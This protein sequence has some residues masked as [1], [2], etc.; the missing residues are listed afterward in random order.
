MAGWAAAIGP[1][2]QMVTGAIKSAKTQSALRELPDPQEFTVSPEMRRGLRMAESR[3]TRGL[4]PEEE[5]A[6]E[7]QQAVQTASAERN[8]RNLG[9]GAF[10]PSTSA[11]YGVDAASRAAQ[12]RAS[13]MRRGEQM[14]IGQAA[15]LQAQENMEISAANE[16]LRQA[17]VALGQAGAAAGQDMSG[18]AMGIASAASGMLGGGDALGGMAAGF[19]RMGIN[20]QVAP[21]ASQEPIGSLKTLPDTALPQIDPFQGSGY[22]EYQKSLSEGMFPAGPMTTKR[23]DFNPMFQPLGPETLFPPEGSVAPTAPFEEGGFFGGKSF[24]PYAPISQADVVKN[25]P[26]PFFPNMTPNT[27]TPAERVNTHGIS[28]DQYLKDMGKSG[29][30][31]NPQYDLHSGKFGSYMGDGMFDLMERN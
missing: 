19:G 31:V 27:T 7:Q 15:R 28:F 1:I 13:E 26:A 17:Q 22:D 14:Y 11:M 10:A 9:L 21:P 25:Y 20:T 6:L 18:G 5:T 24:V 8:L 4:T 3:A 2:I 29:F 16:R 30:Q 23:T 12:L